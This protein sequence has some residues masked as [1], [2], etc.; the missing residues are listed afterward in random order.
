MQALQL[1]DWQQAPELR[2]VSEPE[3]GPGE[4]IV[5]VA[6]AGACH[7]DLHLLYE[8]PPGLLPFEPP[9]TLG[10]ENTGWVAALGAGVTGV[11]VDDP[12]AVYGPWGC[13]RCRPCR[14]GRENYCDHQGELGAMGGGLGRDG[15][16]AP[17]LRVPDARLLV[18]L[19]DGL[20]PVEAAPLSD[21]AL[22]PYH[23]IKRSLGR[24][25]PGSTA[26]VVGVGGLGHLAVQILRA[27]SPARI[28]AID[29]DEQKL[30]LAREIGADHT[31]LAQED[32]ADQVAS[33]TGGRG[34]ELVLDIVGSDESLAAAARMGRM[35]GDLTVVGIAGGTLPFSFFALPYECSLSTTY[36]GAVDELGEVL[37]LAAAGRIRA[38]VT[39]YPLD[40]AVEAYDD[41]RAGTIE[42]RAVVVP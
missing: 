15:G 42:G 18:P 30:R 1:V 17:Y 41:L 23:A 8:F 14:R 4:V 10:H 6:G 9:W 24:L 21:A 13:G 40:R 16:M 37:D 29:T 20:D 36:W 11:R 22:T 31:V 35:Q 12:V 38:H 26:V 2:E 39:R 33:L 34:A 28:I 25:E 27:V 5:R 32:A 19:P 7:S 3:P